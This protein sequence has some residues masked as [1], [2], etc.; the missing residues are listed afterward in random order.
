MKRP[1][2]FSGSLSPVGE[3]ILWHYPY[4]FPGGPRGGTHEIPVDTPLMNRFL[5]LVAKY[6]GTVIIHYEIDK[7]S[8]SGL[9]R[10]LEYGRSTTIILAHGDRADPQLSG[11]V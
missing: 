2:N 8:F 6:L 9:K 4:S 3:F 10:M 7:E 5:G 1:K 11:R